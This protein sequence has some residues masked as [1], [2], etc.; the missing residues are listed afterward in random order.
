MYGEH[1]TLWVGEIQKR[2][3][4]KCPY[5][6]FSISSSG[7]RGGGASPLSPTRAL[8]DEEEEE[9]EEEFGGQ[10]TLV[11]ARPGKVESEF[12]QQ[13]T[14]VIRENQGVS[15]VIISCIECDLKG[16]NNCLNVV[17]LIKIKLIALLTKKLRQGIRKLHFLVCVCVCVFCVCQQSPFLQV[18][19]TI[20]M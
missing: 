16:I 4:G 8:G 11:T 1:F 15:L 5:L 14:L 10:A 6:S 12:S 9:E 2:G 17:I 13:D 7:G 18:V 20:G 3:G 19:S